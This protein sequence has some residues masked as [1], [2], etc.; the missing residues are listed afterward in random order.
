MSIVGAVIAL[1]IAGGLILAVLF[2][3]IEGVKSG[4][5]VSRKLST[6]NYPATVDQTIGQPL[7]GEWLLPTAA[8]AIGDT[9][10]V[11]D[12]GNNRV[13]GVDSAGRVVATLG[14]RFDGLTELQQPM[15]LA[16]DGSRL[17][18]ANSL[19]AEIVV[20]DPAGTVDTILTLDA[21]PG[22]LTPRPI[23]VAVGGDGHLIV[24]DAENHRVLILDSEGETLG[25]FGTGTRAGESVGLNVPNGL[26]VDDAGNIY[27]VD[28]LNGRVVKLSPD[29]EFLRDFSNLA[30]T[31]GSL[32][33]PKGVAVD[34]EGR[35][36]VSDGLQSAIEVFGPEGAYLGVIGRRDT[37]DPSAGSIF[38]TP[39]GLML[40]DDRL[41][42]VDG[43][44]GV[45]VLRLAENSAAEL[46]D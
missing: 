6:L 2:P 7:G 13:L 5:P 3:P 37:A 45:V 10:Y 1:L 36:F 17:Y 28:T 21:R 23:G 11:L 14:P 18:I 9:L 38:D 30:D 16:T 25:T 15:S 42:V 31:A 46:G 27:V 41:L 32:A 43:V 19:A 26:Y 4:V 39:S 44:R 8:A 34:G 35:I 12:T 20:L 33:R 29:G 40:S 22:D 24:S